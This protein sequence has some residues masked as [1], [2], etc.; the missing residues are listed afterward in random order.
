MFLGSINQHVRSILAEMSPAFKG[1]AVFVGC[2]GNFT[3]ERVLQSCGVTQFHGND[4]S[5]YSSAIGHYLA[6]DPLEITIKDP[7]F[8]WLEPWM[9]PGLMSLSTVML[10]TEMFKY[11]GQ[12]SEFHK[13]FAAEYLRTFPELHEAT[14]DRAVRGLDGLSLATYRAQDVSEGRLRTHVLHDGSC[15]RLGRAGL[16]AI[17]R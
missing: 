13:R 8:V 7:D 11:M 6:G 4:V 17:R 15:V 16:R 12:T 2:S 1:R 3:V 14:K 10:A 9:E 5:L